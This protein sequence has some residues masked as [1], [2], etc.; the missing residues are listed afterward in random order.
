MWAA[1]P[2]RVDEIFN[3]FREQL[4]KSQSDSTYSQ[5]IVLILKIVMILEILMKFLK[6]RMRQL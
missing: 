2:G 1:P 4:I 6:T 3:F 5:F